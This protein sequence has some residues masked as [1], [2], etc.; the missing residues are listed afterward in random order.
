MFARPAVSRPS[1]PAS[2]AWLI[3]LALPLVAF[4]ARADEGPAIPAA[5]T[6]SVWVNIGGFSRHFNRHAHYNERNLGFGL[7]WR[8]SPDVALM[9]GVYDNS[10]GKHSQYAAVNWQPWQIGPVKLGAAIGVLNGYPAIERG[11]TFFAA[12]PMATIEGRRFGVNLGVIP[13]M[14]NVDGALLLQFKLRIR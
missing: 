10:L 7:E 9:A 2:R 13:S 5:E 11:G 8:R 6:P 3:A 1:L 12:L 4:A 14:K